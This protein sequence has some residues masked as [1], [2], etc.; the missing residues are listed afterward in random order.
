MLGIAHNGIDYV[1]RDPAT[2]VIQAEDET[3]DLSASTL[4]AMWQIVIGTRVTDELGGPLRIA[5]MSGDVAQGGWSLRLVYGG[6]VDQ[7]GV[8]QPVSGSSA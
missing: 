3:W 2:A 8:D 7:S 1:R 4:K 6:I 5:Q